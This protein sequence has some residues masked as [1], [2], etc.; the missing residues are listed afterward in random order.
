MLRDTHGHPP[1]NQQIKFCEPFIQYQSRAYAP[2]SK[3][4]RQLLRKRIDLAWPTVFEALKSESEV[5]R[6]KNW[7]CFIWILKCRLETVVANRDPINPCLAL[8]KIPVPDSPTLQGAGVCS[9]NA[10]MIQFKLCCQT[11][12]AARPN[13]CQ[14]QNSMNSMKRASIAEYPTPRPHHP[15]KNEAAWAK[16][17]C[18]WP[19]RGRKKASGGAGGST[20]GEMQRGRVPTRGLEEIELSHTARWADSQTV[21]LSS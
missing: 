12:L 8:G 20:K 2:C 6:G 13:C 18:A 1:K 3:L 17:A 19:D 4:A 7:M 10:M 11:W 21:L 15:R 9:L 16:R 14:W 5:G